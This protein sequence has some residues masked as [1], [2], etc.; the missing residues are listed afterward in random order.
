MTGKVLFGLI[1]VTS[2]VFSFVYAASQA[3]LFA[4]FAFGLGVFWLVMEAKNEPAFST[5]FFLAFVALAILRS[6]DQAPVI[7]LL[8]GFTANLAAWDWSRFR[9]RIADETRLEV[10]AL[11]ETRHLQKLAVTAFAGF[12]IALLPVFIQISINFVVVLLLILLT[13]IALRRSMLL[14]RGEP[15]TRGAPPR[16]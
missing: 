8:L 5:I 1:I 7:M 15:T 6:V 4:A 12:V 11:L 16:L 9:A 13:M 10:V 14:I 3:Y 2:S